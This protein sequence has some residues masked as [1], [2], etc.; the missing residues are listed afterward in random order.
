MFGRQRSPS[1][2]Q[3]MESWGPSSICGPKGAGFLKRDCFFPFRCL[4]E[5]IR[6]FAWP[7]SHSLSDRI[8]FAYNLGASW[9]SEADEDQD[10]DRLSVFQYT[11]TL[12]LGLNGRTGAFLEVFGDLPLSTEGD[13][14]HLLDGGLTYLLRDN[15]QLDAFAGIGLSQDADDWFA[16][17]GVT[18]RLPR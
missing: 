12:G 5:L 17:A 8:S 15:L 18:L 7:L 9:E 1:R 13:P 4:G 2:N 11:A 14:E 6:P 16:G 3:R 10:L